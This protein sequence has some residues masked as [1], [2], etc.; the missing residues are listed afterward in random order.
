MCF[1]VWS[2]PC[3]VVFSI[4]CS[5]EHK[6]TRERTTIIVMGGKRLPPDLRDTPFNAFANRADQDKAALVSAA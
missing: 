5:Y 6:Q 2:L 3:G 4:H 1:C